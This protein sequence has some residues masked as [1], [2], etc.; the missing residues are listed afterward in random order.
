M[1]VIWRGNASV[2]GRDELVDVEAS[3][4]M[5]EKSPPL[6]VLVVDDEPLIRW[7][8]RETLVH[9]GHTVKE[10]SD[11]KETLQCISIGSAPDVIF[12]DYRLPDVN[13]LTLLE[14]IRRV[15]PHSPVIMMTAYGT[16]A[17]HAGALKLGAYRVVSKPFEMHELAPLVRQAYESRTP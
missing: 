14:T 1:S 13:D 15:A 10:A 12:L 8:I 17:A 5:L 4:R 6:D 3:P 11:A 16:P 9:A 7:A 2:A